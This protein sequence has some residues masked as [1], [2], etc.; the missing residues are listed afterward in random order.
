MEVGDM[1]R[2]YAPNWSEDYKEQYCARGFV[3]AVSETFEQVLIRWYSHDRSDCSWRA[4]REVEVLS[5]RD[6]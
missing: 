1:I 2:H 3:V 5:S 4:F 6:S